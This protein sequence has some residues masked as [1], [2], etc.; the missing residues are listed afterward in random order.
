MRVISWEKLLNFDSDV[1]FTFVF[2]HCMIAMTTVIL[3]LDLF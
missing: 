2:Y 1:F 3:M